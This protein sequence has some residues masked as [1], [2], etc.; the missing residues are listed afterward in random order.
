MTA[1]GSGPVRV[2]ERPPADRPRERLDSLGPAALSDAEL[3]ALLIRTGS[4]GSGVL[5]VAARLLATTGGLGAIAR[6][7]P[8]ELAAL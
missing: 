3:L 8:A 6:L 1:R 5:D 7:T 2:S 4:G